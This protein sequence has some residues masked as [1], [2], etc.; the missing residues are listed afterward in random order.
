[1]F[2]SCVFC[3]GKFVGKSGCMTPI[4]F[5]NS[6]K[7]CAFTVLGVEALLCYNKPSGSAILLQRCLEVFAALHV[8]W[9]G[10]E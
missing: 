10:N 7:P 9:T 3:L 8:V 6:S 4:G 1:M 2:F 5:Y